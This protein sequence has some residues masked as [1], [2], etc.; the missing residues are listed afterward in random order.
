VFGIV[1]VGLL[2]LLLL[3]AFINLRSS[4]SQVSDLPKWEHR[5]VKN[6]GK[7]GDL[8]DNPD[9]TIEEDKARG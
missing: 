4:S 9:A 2:G 5:A 1:G 6:G 8:V 7:N 3:L